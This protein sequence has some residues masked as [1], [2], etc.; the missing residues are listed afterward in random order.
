MV[1][2]ERQDLPS[3]QFKV[4]FVRNREDRMQIAYDMI[5]EKYNKKFTAIIGHSKGE[6]EDL[7]DYF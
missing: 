3:I 2:Q 4:E 7:R 1:V 5:A 6:I